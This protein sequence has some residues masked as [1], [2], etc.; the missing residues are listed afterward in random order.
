MPTPTPLDENAVRQVLA[1]AIELERQRSGTL[2]ET[3]VREIARDLAIP[4]AAID[5]ALAEY[6]NGADNRVAVLPPSRQWPSRL[7]LGVMVG[8]ALVGLALAFVSV[9]APAPLP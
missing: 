4:T 9:R 2:T 8:I 1:R 5:Q 3:Q 6:R 7:V